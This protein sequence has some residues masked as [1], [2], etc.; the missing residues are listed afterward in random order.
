MKNQVQKWQEKIDFIVMN[1]KVAATF[2]GKIFLGDKEYTVA[3]L[4]EIEERMRIQL[5][6]LTSNNGMR[7]VK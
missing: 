3:E 4:K 5:A 2:G 1:Q 6:I 7:I